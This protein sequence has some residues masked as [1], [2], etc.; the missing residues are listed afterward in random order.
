MRFLDFTL[1]IFGVVATSALLAFSSIPKSTNFLS[2]HQDADAIFSR[3]V[4]KHGKSY[5][6]KEEYEFR[7]EQYFKNMAILNDALEED[8]T[9]HVGENKF[10]DWTKE[11]FK[12]LLGYRRVDLNDNAE[13]ITEEVGI[14]DSVDWRTTGHVTPVKD[15]GSCGSCW[16][17]STTGALEGAHKVAS[18]NLVSLSEQQLVDCAGSFGND[19]C[20]GGDMYAAMLYAKDNLIEDES[21]YPYKG[22]D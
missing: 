1:A 22:K 8:A 10:S 2:D 17:F 12:R 16:A 3:Y 20:D 13:L 5:G 4:A 7:K 9:Y 19:G 6:T 15:Q 14:P 18:G 11:E 21:T